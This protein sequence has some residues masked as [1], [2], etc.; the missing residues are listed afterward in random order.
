MALEYFCCY[1]SYR[2]KV[3]KLSDQEVGRLFRALLE[4]SENGETKELT[5]RESIAFDFI[6]DDIDRQK[7]AYQD[8]CEQSKKNIAKRW[9]T[10]DTTVYDAIPSDTEYSKTKTKTKTNINTCA[11]AASFAAFWEAYPK[12]K[13]KADAEKAF[14]QVKEPIE[15]LLKAIE[16]Q[17]LSPDWQKEGGQFIPY[18][19]TWLRRGAWMDETS[20]LPKQEESSDAPLTSRWIAT[21]DFEGYR[22]Y[23]INGEWVRRE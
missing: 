20:A 12:K 13:N 10:D 21:G 3:A 18:P 7:Q 14:K 1:H 8:R 6:A 9:Y 15:T 17:K 19:A 11:N 23:L 5:G 16:A 22:E 2:K 4:Y